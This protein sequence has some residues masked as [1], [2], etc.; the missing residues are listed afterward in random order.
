MRNNENNAAKF[1]LS[2]PMLSISPKSFRFGFGTRC[3][4]SCLF[5]SSRFICLIMFWLTSVIEMISA[6]SE[7]SKERKGDSEDNC[8]QL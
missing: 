2:T 1:Q 3:A 7:Y 6:L 4:M 5:G 8:W